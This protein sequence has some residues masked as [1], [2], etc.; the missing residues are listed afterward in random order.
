VSGQTASA[1]ARRS[2]RDV[3]LLTLAAAGGWLLARLLVADG[4][5]AAVIPTLTVLAMR[6][7]RG[8]KR[9]AEGEP[10]HAA[11]KFVLGA[12]NE[13]DFGE[14]E[15]Y[16][17]PGL[18]VSMNG[19][20][21]DAGP[22]GDGPALAQESVEYWR[23]MLP[24]LK[25]KLLTEVREKDRIAIEWS[26]TGTHTGDRPELPASGNLVEV[27]GSAFLTLEDDKIVD[28]S[29]V[30]DALALAVQTDAAPAPDWW[31]GRSSG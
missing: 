12:W 11:V 30:F 25:M 9:D 28:A 3:A 18:T 27:Q 6:K 19:F 24:D 16:V 1:D 22:D 2:V 31:P 23:A 7:F 14:A 20:V 5:D 4:I 29:T 8:D 21:Y 15:K 10:K 26:I 17:A 13:G